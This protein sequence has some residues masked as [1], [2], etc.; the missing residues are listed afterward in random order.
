MTI[1]IKRMIPYALFLVFV[2]YVLPL[3][4]QDTGSAMLILLTVIPFLSLVCAITYGH[5]KG[6][7]GLYAVLAALLFIPSLF[8]YYNPS[9]WVYILI[10][11]AVALI[12]NGIGCFFYKHM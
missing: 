12:G 1:V 9:A 4:I 6:F 7:H 10:Y 5:K 2:Y 8:I 11:G 3:F